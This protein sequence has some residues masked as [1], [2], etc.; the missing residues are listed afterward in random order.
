MSVKN[1]IALIKHI[2]EQ[3]HQKQINLSNFDDLVSI[4][5]LEN[6]PCS[7]DEIEKAFLIDWTLRKIKINQQLENKIF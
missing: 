6:L 4:A 1:A 3:Y 2:K 5:N 7:K